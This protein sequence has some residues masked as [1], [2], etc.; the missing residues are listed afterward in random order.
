MIPKLGPAVTPSARCLFRRRVKQLQQAVFECLFTQIPTAPYCIGVENSR[1]SFRFSGL[2]PGR[3]ED[4]PTLDC[5]GKVVPYLSAHLEGAK[6]EK[7][8][9]A[10]HTQV[11]SSPGALDEMRRILYQHIAQTVPAQ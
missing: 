11:T 3:S 2:S 4:F 6:T 8:V 5:D 1:L 9:H 10:S 7:I